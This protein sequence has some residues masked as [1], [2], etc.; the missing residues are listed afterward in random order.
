MQSGLPEGNPEDYTIVETEG[1]KIRISE[2]MVFE[3]DIPK[4]VVFPKRN[5]EKRVG[6]PNMTTW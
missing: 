4:I 6:V 2:K 1:L 5:G 3:G